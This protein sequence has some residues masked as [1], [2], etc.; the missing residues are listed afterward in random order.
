MPGTIGRLPA[1]LTAEGQHRGA[2]VTRV[3]LELLVVRVTDLVG[4]ADAP[5]LASRPAGGEIGALGDDHVAAVAAAAL[6]VASRRRAV[7]RGRHHLEEAGADGEQR[8]LEPL[9][10]PPGFAMAPLESEDLTEGLDDGRELSGHETD[11]PH[12]QVHGP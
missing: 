1:L 7:T 3:E 9:L 6:E 10:P 8:V 2:H 4:H 12:P 11:L 5:G